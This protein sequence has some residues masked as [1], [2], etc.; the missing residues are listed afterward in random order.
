[1]NGENLPLNGEKMLEIK[2][3]KVLLNGEIKDYFNFLNDLNNYQ[4]LFP[5]EKISDWKSDFDFCS[6]KVQNVYTLEMI[7][8][9]TENKLINLKSGDSSPFK[10]TIKITLLKE[11]NHNCSAQIF[12]EA[13]L[14][15]GLKMMV[16][17]PLNELFN[18]MASQIEKAISAD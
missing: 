17:K 13:N 3:K 6:F 10:F 2:S 8:V 7:K 16:G 5:K 14:N 18:F 12:C 9:S 4:L 15:A 1:M 11:E